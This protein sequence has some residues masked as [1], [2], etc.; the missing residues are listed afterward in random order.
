MLDAA[1]SG[2]TAATQPCSNSMAATSESAPAVRPRTGSGRFALAHSAE[3]NLLLVRP[4]H[5]QPVYIDTR[6]MDA[7]GIDRADG[8]D[9]LDFGNADLA[10]GRGRLVEIACGLAELEVAGLV[11][12]P[13]LDDRQVGAD[14]AFK[15]VVL[16]V[17]VF[18]FLALRHER[19][20]ASLGVE[21]RNARA[22]RAHAFRERPLRAKFD[23]QFAR[24]ILPFEFLVLADIGRDHL[25]HLPRAEQLAQTLTVDPG[26]VAGDGQ[27][28]DPRSND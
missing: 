19:A 20:D 24:R 9:F 14:A 7:V 16:P 11:G 6:Q 25:L 10:R 3:F 23:L 27:V 15:D 22:T 1:I 2:I 21:A 12:A 28:F 8:D 5:D 26:I 4:A 18:H 13:A 17:E